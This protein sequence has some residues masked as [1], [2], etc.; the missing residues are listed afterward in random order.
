MKD[1]VPYGGFNGELRMESEKQQ[2]GTQKFNNNGETY[3]VGKDPFYIE[4]KFAQIC[5]CYYFPVLQRDPLLEQ[6]QQKG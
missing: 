6:E 2:A 1:T 3:Y 4:G 5:V